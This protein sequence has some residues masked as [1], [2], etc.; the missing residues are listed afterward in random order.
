MK[1][2][3]VFLIV[4]DSFGIGS[5][6]DAGEF[7]DEGAN[8]LKTV[9]K[10]KG[11]NVENMKKLGLFNIDG[12]NLNYSEENPKGVYGRLRE[13]SR[14]KDTTTGHWE[15]AGIIKDTPFPTYPEGFPEDIIK[16]FEKRTGKGVICNKPYSGTEVIKDF[17]EEHIKTG[18][19]ILYTSADSVF[20]LAAHDSIVPLTELYE[21]CKVARGLLK[22][23]HAVARVI[24]RPFSGE[25]PEFYRTAGRHDYSLEPTK[26]I[27]DEI[28]D[29]CK[30]VIAVGKIFDIFAGKGI[31][32][33]VYTK[34]NT[35]G[36][37]KTL[38]YMDKDFSG[39]LFLNLVDFDMK[40]GHRNDIDGYAGAISYFDEK[41]KDIMS[42]LKED[43][44]LIITADH[45]CDPGFPGTD[46]TREYVPF[47]MYGEGI[48]PRNLGTVQGLDFVGKTVL[49]LLEI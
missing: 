33:H 9:S 35:E 38:D 48:E 39:L 19:L 16:E 31:T 24:A 26:T 10:S 22:G 14:G 20:Q 11:F 12:V 15:M 46:H 41:L 17:G 32:E 40:Y 3:R 45:G 29:C 36:I 6:P 7:G 2:K 44:V 25:Y 13:L 4:L 42:K 30:D 34:D 18:K 49:K 43:D 1:Y 21:Y 47:L 23:E 5:L 27:L 37:E 28:K 8:T